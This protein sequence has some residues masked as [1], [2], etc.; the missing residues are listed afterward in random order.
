M[1]SPP[2][3]SSSATREKE[4]IRLG[5]AGNY[6]WW[7]LWTMSTA[8]LMVTFDFSALS[9]CLPQLGVVFHANP[10]TL[11]WLNI[12]YFIVS[13]SLTLTLAK[14]GD[15]LG[16]RRCFLVGLGVFCVGLAVASLSGTIVHLLVARVV[17]G[18]GGAMTVALSTAITV[19]AFPEDERGR[20][21]GI[22]TGVSSIG[23]IAGPVLGGFL[24]DLLGWQ[25]I[26]YMRVP[27]VVACMAMTKFV[28][29]EQERHERRSFRFDGWGSLT[30]FGWLSTS[31]LLLS[32]GNRWGFTSLPIL[33][34][35][36]G[37]LFLFC[38]FIVAER[39]AVEPVANLAFFKKGAFSAAIVSSMATAVGSSSVAFLL[40]F[41]FMD[42]LGFSGSTV[43]AYLTLLALPAVLFSPISGRVSD[44]IGS[45]I[46]SASGTAL[47]CCGVFW[48]TYTA[49]VPSRIN[50]CVGIALVGTGMGIF[51]PPNSSALIGSVPRSSLA[52]ASAIASMARNVGTSVAIALS[53]VLFGFYES[54]HLVRLKSE[55]MNLLLARKTA[56]IYGFGDALM[57][58]VP[59]MLVGIVATLVFGT[60]M[61]GRRAS[62]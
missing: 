50:L 53:G 5:N 35:G 59:V 28:V 56:V 61:A 49:V 45:K 52:V 23:L 43:G 62:S 51:H 40:P 1:G 60:P 29:K 55:G 22:L 33:A 34:L 17:S 8:M 11:G 3:V 58:V 20:A 39:H 6:K 18:A 10:V 7:A 19:A 16:R 41:Y 15:A 42:G 13:L 37:A 14:V 4:L 9:A 48:L 25:A 32:L 12:T 2:P 46:L 27:V 21:V 26:F 30:L 36:G 57:V 44:R 54:R 38:T 31:L 24:L 47:G